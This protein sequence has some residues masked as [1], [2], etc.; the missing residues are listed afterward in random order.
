MKT[1]NM[2]LDRMGSRYPSR[3]SFSRSMLRTIVKEKWK[4]SKSKFDLNKDGYGTAVYEVQT[5]NQTYSLNKDDS[6]KIRISD[7]ILL[8]RGKH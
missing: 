3:L 5:K 7:S 6:S 2:T 8:R 1:N 4:I